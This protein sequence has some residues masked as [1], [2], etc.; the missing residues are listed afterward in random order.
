VLSVACQGGEVWKPRLLAVPV[1][2]VLASHTDVENY[3]GLH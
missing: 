1:L 2:Y 3:Y